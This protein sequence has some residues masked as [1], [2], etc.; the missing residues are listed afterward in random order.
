MYGTIFSSLGRRQFCWRPIHKLTCWVRGT[1]LSTLELTGRVGRVEEVSERLP[2]ARRAH[3]HREHG[4]VRPLSGPWLRFG[5][6]GWGGGGLG[7]WGWG[8]GLG[9]WVRDLGFRFEG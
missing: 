8:G 9:F 3:P 6:E 2:R 4:Q 1:N 5:V 7:V